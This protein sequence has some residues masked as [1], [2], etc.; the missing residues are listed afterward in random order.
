MESISIFKSKYLKFAVLLLVLFELSCSP[1]YS[2][3]INVG[4]HSRNDDLKEFYFSISDYYRVP[5]RDV[6]LIRYENPFIRD[7]ELPILFFIVNEAHVQPDIILRYRKIG[8]SWY[9][10]MVRFR[11]KPERVFERYIIVEGPPYGKAW[12]YHKKKQKRVIAFR[13]V[14][15]IEFANIHFI[16]NYYGEKPEIVIETKKK[17]S[18][19]IDVH[20]EFYRK[21]KI[22]DRRL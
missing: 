6:Y 16:T 10:I 21:H 19:Y 4:M 2:K 5:S 15:I 8:Y 13:D 9:D 3:D 17:Y 14:D 7:D 18:R 22:K 20:R 12:G 11:L 1:S